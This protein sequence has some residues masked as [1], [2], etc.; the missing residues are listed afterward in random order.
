VTYVPRLAS[1]LPSFLGCFQSFLI[2]SWYASDFDFPTVTAAGTER[3]TKA[4]RFAVTKWVARQTLGTHQMYMPIWM[5][6]VFFRVKKCEHGPLEFCAPVVLTGNSC[7][8]VP[9]FWAMGVGRRATLTDY[10]YF[11]PS[12]RILEPTYCKIRIA[13]LVDSITV[14]SFAK[15][16]EISGPFSSPS[17]ASS[18]I[19]VCPLSYGLVS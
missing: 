12:P 13:D 7:T 19:F 9:D 8:C 17:H 16:P 1:G 18:A 2:L 4:K 10:F 15:V 11:L 14:V 3:A 5:Y 6:S